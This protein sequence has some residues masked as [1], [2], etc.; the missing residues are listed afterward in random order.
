MMG[1]YYAKHPNGVAYTLQRG[2]PHVSKNQRDKSTSTYEH[3]KLGDARRRCKEHRSSGCSVQG[4]AGANKE[5]TRRML[6]P[7]LHPLQHRLKK[8][9]STHEAIVSRRGSSQADWAAEIALDP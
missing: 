5:L 8:A 7:A 4:N 3:R 9:P 2:P 6:V 1:C